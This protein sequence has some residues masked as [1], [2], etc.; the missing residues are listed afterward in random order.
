MLDHIIVE[1]G[2]IKSQLGLLAGISVLDPRT[3]SVT[4]YD[5][6]VT[7]YNLSD[8][9]DYYYYYYHY[10]IYLCCNFP[11]IALFSIEQL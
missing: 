1:S 7:T 9:F 5:P 10:Y 11:L 6:N 8:N 4:P 3:L 2:G